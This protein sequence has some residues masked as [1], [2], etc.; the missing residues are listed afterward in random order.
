M[1]RGQGEEVLFY[2]EVAWPIPYSLRLLLQLEVSQRQLIGIGFNGY[3]FG[4]VDQIVDK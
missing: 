2:T 4:C 3:S 1:V